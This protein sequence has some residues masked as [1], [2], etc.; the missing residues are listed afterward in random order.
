[1][2]SIVVG[3]S[4]Q[5]KSPARPVKLS[6]LQDT[7]TIEGVPI[8]NGFTEPPSQMF[9]GS[10]GL[11]LGLN[12]GARAFLDVR[13]DVA[14]SGVRRWRRRLRCAHT[15]ERGVPPKDSR[16]VGAMVWPP[17]CGSTCHHHRRSQTQQR[18]RLIAL[19]AGD[20]FG[21]VFCF[22]LVRHLHGGG[23]VEICVTVDAHDFT[24]QTPID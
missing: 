24:T 6:F 14:G 18:S 17:T 19:I 7:F 13:R 8:F 11:G 2:P 16:L 9:V 10:Q 22:C 20:V 15:R 4:P 3:S 1:M 21:R 23:G 12:E 5:I